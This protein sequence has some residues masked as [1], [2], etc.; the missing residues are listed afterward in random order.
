MAAYSTVVKVF[1]KHNNVYI[2]KIRLCNGLKDIKSWVISKIVKFLICKG[3][4]S[5][6]FPLRYLTHIDM[7]RL[8]L[9]V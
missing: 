3:N 4:I 6:K 1:G 5:G 2:L 8:D 9:N 7:N